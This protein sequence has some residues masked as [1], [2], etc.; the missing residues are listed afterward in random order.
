M[1][2]RQ[3]TDWAEFRHWPSGERF[4]RLHNRH[5]SHNTLWTRV[6]GWAAASLCC[7]VGFVLVFMPGPGFVFFGI[8]GGLLAMQSHWVAQRLD[9]LE[10]WLRSVRAWWQRRERRT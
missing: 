2:E 4:V 5:R 9:A 7:A 8:A 3:R 6:L 10:L 1:L